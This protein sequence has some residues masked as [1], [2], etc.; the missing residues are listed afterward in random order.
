MFVEDLYFPAIILVFSF[1]Q[2][3]V[4]GCVFKSYV[5]ET[6]TIGSFRLSIK[7]PSFCL[8][9]TNCINGWVIYTIEKASIELYNLDNE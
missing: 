4:V 5:F 2:K 7:F 6:L 9:V 1:F 8:L 3:K